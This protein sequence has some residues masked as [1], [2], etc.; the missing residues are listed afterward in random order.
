LTGFSMDDLGMTDEEIPGGNTDPDEIPEEPADPVTRPGD[1]WTLGEHRILCGDSTKVEDVARVMG[2]EMVDCVLTDPP[3]GMDLDTDYSKMPSTKAE[4]NKTYQ[5]IQGDDIDFD[6]NS[7]A[8]VGTNEAFWFGADYYA[9]TL[10]CAG[11]SW[12]V[13]DKRVDDKFD[14]MF[15][16]AFE[17]AWSKIKHKREIIRC[18]NTLFSG[19]TDAKNKAHPTQKPVKVLI[20]IV[21]KY[22]KKGCV[23]LDYFSGSGTTIIACEQL[24]RKCRA[25]EISPAYVDVSVQRW[26]DFTGQDPVRH[27]GVK[28]SELTK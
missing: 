1:M 16:S 22:T 9:K 13:W 8:H 6:F 5:P 14:R 11:G 26:A 21:E 17:L 12:L 24:K 23:V 7:V 20:W 28:W 2:G 27:D 3:Y 25:I 19:E 4:G 10:P 18:N 15:G